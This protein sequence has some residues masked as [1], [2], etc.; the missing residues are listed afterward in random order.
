MTD[1][2]SEQYPTILA[3]KEVQEGVNVNTNILQ[4][5]GVHDLRN[6]DLLRDDLSFE[7][8]R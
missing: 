6:N 1:E 4:Y 2:L 5:E 7:F 3:G 8:I